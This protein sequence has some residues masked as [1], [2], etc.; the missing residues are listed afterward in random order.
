MTAP[1]ELPKPNLNL[2]RSWW[3]A[4][5]A[6]RLI[7]KVVS[8][9]P[10]YSTHLHRLEELSRRVRRAA[11]SEEAYRKNRA[12]VAGGPSHA[13][14]FSSGYGYEDPAEETRVARMYKADILSGDYRN[15]ETPAL[16]VEADA[17]ITKLLESG[18][19]KRVV[20]FGVSYA[21]LD[22][23]LAK[24]FPGVQFIGIDRSQSVCALNRNEF[25]LPNIEFLASDIFEWIEGQTDL[26]DTLFFHMRTAILLP[27]DFVDRFTP[28]SQ[29]KGWPRSAV[30]SRSGS[31]AKQIRSLSRAMSRGGRCS[32]G[33]RFT[34]TITR[35][36]VPSAGTRLPTLII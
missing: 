30:S 9:I 15:R 14:A 4:Y 33:T 34:Y 32:S 22:G 11:S 35:A 3:A 24:R 6:Q 7:G 5:R 36:F 1:Y 19:I 27:E 31:A 2:S 8:K 29:P 23:E 18:I 16:M 25:D 10:G 13:A 28:K 20:N 26:S 21:H 17:V 12:R